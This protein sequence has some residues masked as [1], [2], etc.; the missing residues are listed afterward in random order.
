VSA[1]TREGSC[2]PSTG[3]EY[4]C[5]LR[6]T[7]NTG[8]R[9]QRPVWMQSALRRRPPVDARLFD[10]TLQSR[11]MSSILS[12]R[13]PMG[14]SP[15]SCKYQWKAT[16]SWAAARPTVHANQPTTCFRATRL[17]LPVDWAA[18]AGLSPFCEPYQ[19]FR[20]YYDRCAHRVVHG[21]PVSIGARPSGEQLVK[22]LQD[23]DCFA[24][25]LVLKAHLLYDCHP[26][27]SA[28][29]AASADLITSTQIFTSGRSR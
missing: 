9:F 12:I 5:S 14:R 1:F 2:L 11:G 7:R 13:W 28:P 27:P 6:A 3:T 29:A 16:S 20:T 26:R 23:D 18:W 21:L 17:P 10:A 19:D 24:R 25:C 4:G 22:N 15:R 8:L